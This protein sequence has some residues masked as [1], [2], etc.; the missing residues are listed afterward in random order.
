MRKKNHKGRG[1]GTK[2]KTFD[3]P[4]LSSLTIGNKKPIIARDYP[5]PVE[6]VIRRVETGIYDVNPPYQRGSIWSKNY[7]SKLISSILQGIR[8]N[9]IHI[10]LSPYDQTSYYIIDGK[11]RLEAIQSFKN[12]EI[13]VVIE[14]KDMT[15]LKLD[16]QVLMRSEDPDV[17][18]YRNKWLDYSLIVTEHII[19]DRDITE[20]LAQHIKIFRNVNYSRELSSEEV[21][22]CPSFMT[23]K[24]LRF[25]YEDGFNKVCDMASP[26]IKSNDRL[27]ALGSLLTICC[28][29]FGAEL[30]DLYGFAFRNIMSKDLTPVAENFHNF[31][32]SNGIYANTIFDI[33]L[34]KKIDMEEV[35][36]R[37]K[38]AS[39]WFY[40]ILTFHNDLPKGILKGQLFDCM[41]FLLKKIE[42]GI[43]T[44]NFVYA[45]GNLEKMYEWFV[46]YMDN[47]FVYL[48]EIGSNDS[49]CRKDAIERRHN[50]AETTWQQFFQDEIRNKKISA[51]DKRKA[52]IKSQ[53]RCKYSG[54]RIREDNF[55]VD[56][57][58]PKSYSEETKYMVISETANTIKGGVHPDFVETY[59]KVVTQEDCDVHRRDDAKRVKKGVESK[60][61]LEELK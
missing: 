24:F 16:F 61:I 8:I 7:K 2:N 13:W 19:E 60:N 9:T 48:K 36:N 52:L 51:L 10:S 6:I 58:I 29:C 59:I 56:H 40:S 45:S 31:L 20:I 25:A 35:C 27:E 57:I 18:L 26:G 11:Q 37:V 39:K 21:M 15:M 30:N 32:W 23:R 54:E 1:K 50:L 5:V 41:I 4:V 28:T 53:A 14:K 17:V 22:L 46:K 44:D 43:L 33:D 49:S 47:R 3:I 12:G 34:M 55:A 42:K 38:R